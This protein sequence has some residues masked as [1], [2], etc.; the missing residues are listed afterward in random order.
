MASSKSDRRFRKLLRIEPGSKVDLAGYDCGRKFGR[1]EKDGRAELAANLDRLAGLQERLYAQAQH[2]VLVILQGID[3]SGKDGTIRV[4][5]GTFNPQGT[6]VTSF[7]EPTSEEAAHDFLWRVHAACPGKGEIGLFNR[8]HYEQVLIVRVHELE[9]EASWRRHYGEIRHWER[10]LVDEGTTIV[11]FFLAIDSEEQ[12]KRFQDRIDDPT[13]RWKFSTADLAERKL[14]GEYQAAFEEML[15]ETSTDFAPWYLVPS[16][17]N[18]L[19]E[20][21]VSEILADSIEDLKPTYPEPAGHIEDI[22]VK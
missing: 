19:R 11:K 21:A 3:A 8:S 12:R 7:K 15:A 10:M 22:K 16:N 20:L 5:A 13:K 1:E 17:H 2:A 9:P 4:I 6:S 14:W 18:W